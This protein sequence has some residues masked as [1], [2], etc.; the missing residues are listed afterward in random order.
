M[1]SIGG[2]MTLTNNGGAVAL[3]GFYRLAITALPRQ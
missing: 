1:N 3:Q 2:L